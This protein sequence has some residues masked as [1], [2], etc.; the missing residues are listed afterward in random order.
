MAQ[1]WP[2][3]YFF[4]GIF[5]KV[6]FVI[7]LLLMT[8]PALWTSTNF[9]FNQTLSFF[10]FMVLS[11]QSDCCFIQSMSDSEGC[12][13]HMFHWLLYKRTT[14]FTDFV[15]TGTYFIKSIFM[16]FSCYVLRLLSFNSVKL[17]LK[18]S[19]W[20]MFSLTNHKSKVLLSVSPLSSFFALFWKKEINP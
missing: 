9:A 6:E 19:W 3:S 12:Y 18:V 16:D 7:S 17:I 10:Y 14:L 15:E 20:K 11:E 2:K 5:F 13:M 8:H 4:L 1:Q